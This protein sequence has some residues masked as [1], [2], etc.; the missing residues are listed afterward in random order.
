MKRLSWIFIIGVL[1]LSGYALWGKHHRAYGENLVLAKAQADASPSTWGNTTQLPINIALSA[2]VAY[3]D[4][5]YVV[6][7][8]SNFNS[9][10]T[11]YIASINED[12]TTGKW[13]KTSSMNR[14]RAGH[15]VVAYKGY[16]YVAGGT[17]NSVEYVKIN[18]DG[19]LGKWKETS[20]LQ[21]THSDFGF[22]VYNDYLYA[23]GGCSG[24]DLVSSSTVEYAKINSNG[25]VAPW[26]YD[27]AGLPRSLCGLEA[28]VYNGHIYIAGGWECSEP[29]RCREVIMNPTYSNQVFY[30]KLNSNGTMG[31]WS[32]TNSMQQARSSFGLSVIDGYIFAA[33][34][35]NEKAPDNIL[36]SSE[37]ARI[38]SDGTLEKWE[39]TLPL[40]TALH[41]I[42][43][44]VNGDYIYTFGGNKP[45]GGSVNMVQYAKIDLK[46][47]IAT[48]VK[49]SQV[50]DKKHFIDAV[51]YNN[52][53]YILQRD[54]K[55]I[56]YAK[57]H[58]DGSLGEWNSTSQL[59]T[60]RRDGKLGIFNGYIYAVGGEYDKSKTDS[61]TLNSVEYAAINTDGK[62]GNWKLTEAMTTKRRFLGLAVNNG[63][64]YAI[65]GSTES[66]DLKTVEYAQINT[67]NGK[68]KPWQTTS[69]LNTQ[70]NFI[71]SFVYKNRLY[72]ISPQ[73]NASNDYEYTQINTDGSLGEWSTDQFVPSTALQLTGVVNTG[74]TVYIIGG[75]KGSGNNRQITSTVQ[76]APINNNDLIGDFEGTVA[77]NAKRSWFGLIYY[78]DHIYA[79]GGLDYDPK[80]PGKDS[81]II[82]RDVEY[83]VFKVVGLVSP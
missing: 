61:V 3:D 73:E 20:N 39:T 1:L 40:K 41:Q 68:L 78:K 36:S 5:V 14:A 77:L 8:F 54:H 75:N 60:I 29:Y 24:S 49:T 21:N 31:T 35:Y 59:T 71:S 67:N 9:L 48:W 83:S 64:I 55:T 38:K 30:V 2:S 43:M 66:D 47:T 80:D 17:G 70:L 81:F 56:L 26:K 63:Y 11:V 4:Y 22:V 10:N 6:G 37:Y 42:S 27:K 82:P 50:P 51:A 18:S 44:V 79:I 76:Y 23:L 74:N 53:M 65:G 58:S 45:V 12:G 28:G 34:G 52:Y 72:A 62:L 16:L 15:S 57:V 33:G 19:T 13:N 7:G 46:S 69:T 32:K 25:S